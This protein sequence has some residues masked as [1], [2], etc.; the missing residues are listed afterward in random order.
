[1][2]GH[3]F[4]TFQP[5]RLLPAEHDALLAEALARLRAHDGG[6]VLCDGVP[7]LPEKADHGDVDVLAAAPAHI[8]VPDVARACFPEATEVVCN[9]PV[10]SLAWRGAQLDVV[11]VGADAGDLAMA[12]FFMAFGDVG[13]LLGTMCKRHGLTLGQNG[14]DVKLLDEVVDAGPGGAMGTRVRLTRDPRAI[15]AFLGLDYDAHANGFATR[16]AVADFVRSCRLYNA[17]DFAALRSSDRRK[18]R[19]RPFFAEFVAAAE[20]GAAAARAACRLEGQRAAL[21]HFQAESVVEEAR[22]EFARRE[23]VRARFSAAPFQALGL[24]GPALGAAM[25]AF[26]RHHG[27]RSLTEVWALARTPG[28]VAAAVADFCRAWGHVAAT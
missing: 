18:A 11:R 28:V 1:M 20:A 22:A 16:A 13:C 4:A 19:V 6:A 12:R 23:A 24:D 9:G 2:G 15:C 26:V 5:R 8:S 27:G 7:P 10:T 21:A 17:A 3:A 25:G 14:L